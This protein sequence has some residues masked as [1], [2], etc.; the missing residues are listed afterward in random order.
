MPIPN[1]AEFLRQR[2]ATSHG[3]CRYWICGS[4]LPMVLAMNNDLVL[5]S[6]FRVMNIGLHSAGAYLKSLSKVC[7]V[8]QD[9]SSLPQAER[10]TLVE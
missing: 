3:G 9:I 2:M 10:Q 6:S 8:L 7:G 4:D 1:A 5:G